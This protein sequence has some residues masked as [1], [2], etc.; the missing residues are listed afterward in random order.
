MDRYFNDYYQQFVAEIPATFEID[1][2]VLGPDIPTSTAQA[3]T[4]A[5][6]ALAQ[7][8][9]YIGYFR[10]G[11]TLLIIFI[12]LLIL[13]IVLIYREV[14]GASR[15]LGITFLTYGA[16]EYIGI[17]IGKHFLRTGLPLADLP[18]SLQSWLPQLAINFLRPLEMLSLGLATGGLVLIIVSFVYRPR[19]ALP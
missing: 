8:R 1:E 19:P 17:L 5:E 2:S 18:S 12:L 11:Y 3:L 10:L 15:N 6:T 9:L 14:R 4:D 7:A 13:G 16:L